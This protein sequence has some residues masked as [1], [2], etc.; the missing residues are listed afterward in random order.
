MLTRSID[1]DPF[2]LTIEE[3]IFRGAKRVC[4]IFAVAAVTLSAL[5]LANIRSVENA[6]EFIHDNRQRVADLPDRI[7]SEIDRMSL[8]SESPSVTVAIPRDDIAEI[9]RPPSRRRRASSQAKAMPRRSP[10]LPPRVI[11]MPSNSRWSRRPPWAK[12]GAA[13][14]A[15]DAGCGAAPR[16]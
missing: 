3:K 6:A 10:S 12:V 14:C 9:A 2:D 16:R 7:R 13:Y 4:I 5:D 8:A 1:L 15:A 11:S